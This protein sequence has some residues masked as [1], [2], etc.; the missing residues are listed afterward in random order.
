MGKSSM[1]EQ[2]YKQLKRE[3]EEASK[4]ASRA[5]GA[6]DELTRRLKQDFEC[7]TFEQG[8]KLLTK[9]DARARKAEEAYEKAAESYREKWYHEP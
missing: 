1:T 6:L 4:R 5:Q 7:D 9:L 2:E 3:V 8:K